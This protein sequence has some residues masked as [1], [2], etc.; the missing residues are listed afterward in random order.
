MLRLI[1]Q[2]G[3]IFWDW[4]K[5]FFEVSFVNLYQQTIDILSQLIA[6]DTQSFLPNLALIDYLETHLTAHG[7]V[8][9]KNHNS[10]KTKANLFA[11]L[12]ASNGDTNGGILLSGH[13]DVVPVAGQN[14]NSDPFTLTEKDGKLYGRG[15]SDMKGFIACAIASLPVLSRGE[16][17]KP[18]HFAFSYDEEVGCLGARELVDELQR[19]GI[20]PEIA[21]IG[22]P[23]QMQIIEGHKSACQYT[24]HF[25]GLASHGSL[26]DLGVNAV[27][28]ATRYI[29]KL[30]EIKEKLKTLAPPN[31]TYAPPYSTLQIGKIEGGNAHNIVA[32]KCSVGWE[33]RALQK[34]DAQFVHTQIDDYQNSELLVQMKRVHADS[35]IY[36]EIIAEVEGLDIA[37]ASEAKEFMGELLGQNTAGVVSFGT[38]AGLFALLGT[39]TIV[40]GPGSIKQAHKANEYIE[41]DQLKLCLQ[42]LEKLAKSNQ[43]H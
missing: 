43:N 2:Y 6:F 3:L 20:A 41:I 12:P 23:T 42:M 35:H 24:T 32:D 9:F 1:R 15:T 25:E 8:S 10:D 17:T 7:A 13:S 31:N 37:Q 11:T 33:F 38:E 36:K 40:C 34:S 5:S 16:R 28:Y 18:I 39:S 29:S 27:E 26:P 21:I 4:L 14:W 22:E 30:L 19:L